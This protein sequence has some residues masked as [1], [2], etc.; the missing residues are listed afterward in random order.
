M[1]KDKLIFWVIAITMIGTLATL[2]T[3][4]AGAEQLNLVDYI[5]KEKAVPVANYHES[6]ITQPCDTQKTK[7][8]AHMWSSHNLKAVNDKDWK[9]GM[10]QATLETTV[11]ESIDANGNKVI[12]TVTKPT[13]Y[14]N[15]ALQVEEHKWERVGDATSGVLNLLSAGGLML[16]K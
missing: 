2:L 7:R 10:L 11:T 9:L 5:E 14:T 16:L 3:L 13:E 15:T 4:T 8:R 1:N 6:H 12:T